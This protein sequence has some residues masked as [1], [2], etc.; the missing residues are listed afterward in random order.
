M[1]Q[2]SCVR[3][4]E[5]ARTLQRS[6]AMIGLLERPLLMSTIITITIYVYKKVV[7]FYYVHPQQHA[8]LSVN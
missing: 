6:L 7:F 3:C 1:I 2:I 8:C 5:S 4:N